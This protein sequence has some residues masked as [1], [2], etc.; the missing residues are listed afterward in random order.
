MP[1][2][3]SSG[4]T[5]WASA[6]A[7]AVAI[8]ETG[9]GCAPWP[10]SETFGLDCEAERTKRVRQGACE[11]AEEEVGGESGEVGGDLVGSMVSAKQA[12]AGGEEEDTKVTGSS[13]GSSWVG[14]VTS[15]DASAQPF[16]HVAHEK[17][18]TFSAETL[19]PPPRAARLTRAI[20]KCRAK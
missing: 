6:S 5:P 3:T 10:T 15:S 14:A 20:Y 19:T 7:A 18:E 12:S 9:E 8:S 11:A 17:S 2:S 13:G 1:S 4:C 16:S